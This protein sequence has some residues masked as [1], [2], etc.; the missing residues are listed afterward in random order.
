MEPVSWNCLVRKNSI[1]A[2]HVLYTLPSLYLR[3]AVN[4]CRIYRPLIDSITVVVFVP[5]LSSECIVAVLF[6]ACKL[7]EQTSCLVS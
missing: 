4:H 1:A 2:G 7:S 6:K 5:F 3:A